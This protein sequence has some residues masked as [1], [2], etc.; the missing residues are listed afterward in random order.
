M[1]EV[2]QT[3]RLR[4]SDRDRF[5]I[6]SILPN[7]LGNDGR[8]RMVLTVSGRL[9]WSNHAADRYLNAG[10][11]FHATREFVRI[12]D[13]TQSTAF[14]AFLAAA[15]PQMTSWYYRRSSGDGGLLLRAWR[16]DLRPEPVI[17]VV[18][19]STGADFQPKWA[20]FASAFGLTP[21]ENR[22]AAGLLEGRSADELASNFQLTVGTVRTHI[23]RL[24]GKLGVSSRG[25]FFRAL[26]PFRLS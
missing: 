8:N 24:Y 19:H 20:D 18:F 25:E 4:L 12:A 7:W 1:G 13:P 10:V 26:A 11:D 21:G 22:M 23:K 6:G 9:V 3:R 15:S 5:D 2:I 16:I 14:E 17:G